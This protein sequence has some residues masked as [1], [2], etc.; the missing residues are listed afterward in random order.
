MTAPA[1]Q[2]RTYGGWSR[3]RSEGMFGLAWEATVL[4]FVFVVAA[5]VTAVLISF[6]AALVVAGSEALVW[7][8]LAFRANGRTG[9]ERA[10]VMAQWL[11]TWSRKEN[12]Y[13]SGIFS[14]H[15]SAK[16]PG[17]LAISQLYEGIDA[18]G[19]RFGIVHMPKQALYTVMLR[20][21]P[22]GAE[23]VDQP[24]VD[25]WVA[26]WGQ[27]VAS[28]GGAN[29]IVAITPVISTIPETGHR[30]AHEVDELTRPDAP[31]LAAAM[32]TELA[33][34][35]PSHTV[36]LDA[37]CAIT[38]RATTP[39]RRRQPAEQ[40]V[41]IGRRLPGITVA[42]G[43]AGVRTRPMT[44]DEVTATVRR[45]FDPAA[46]AD[47]E[48]AVAT[49]D[50]HGIGWDEAGPISYLERTG[51]LEHDGAV[52][53]TWEMDAAP[54]GT[55]DERVLQWLLAPTPE[56]SRKRVALVLRPHAAADAAGIVDDD[57][58]NA[59][60]ATQSGKGVVS[61]HAT[62]R[63]GA[64]EQAREEQ[65]RGHGVT[66]FGVLITVTSPVGADLPRI[67]ALTQDLSVQARLR[68]RR[69]H[70][71][72]AAAFAGSLG[73]GVLLPEMATLPRVMAA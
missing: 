46:E 33:Q 1:P 45:A 7:A 55:V 68:V 28:V 64:T 44:A 32:M 69:A 43:Q 8:P 25:Q 42:L 50:G 53:T 21:W 26:A 24:V 18:N 67:D 12:L 3:P 11:R 14:R 20:V 59:L 17:L 62:L 27:F 31:E 57:Y 34:T 38:F 4:G 41:E 56:L 63:V 29:D 52:S 19:Y 9:Y 60:V 30:L 40:A 39:E 70:Y 13:R 37:W 2:R 51:R 22:A 23:N 16:L 71:Y 61:A 73:V 72:Q 35:L 66:R 36:R 15:G 48:T 5:M 54:S 47:L 58:K 65:A 6:T 10:V 49:T